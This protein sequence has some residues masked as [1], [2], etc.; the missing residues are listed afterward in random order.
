MKIMGY[1]LICL[2][3]LSCLCLAVTISD[4]P[5]SDGDYTVINRSVKEGYFSLYSSGNFNPKQAVSRR[6]ASLIINKIMNSMREKKSSISSSDLGDLK[7][8]SETFKPIYS[9]YEDKLRTLELHNQELKHNQDLLHSDIS[10]LNQSIHAFRKERKLLYGLLAG[11][12][13]LGIIF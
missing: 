8:L 13:L 4:V 10:E 12:G 6:E 9:E 5:S 11:V 2:F 7:Q 1:V 3:H